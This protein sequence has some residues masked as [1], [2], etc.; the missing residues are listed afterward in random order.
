MGYMGVK[1]AVDLLNGK[2]ITLFNT[3]IESYSI[4]ADNI[5]EYD[6]DAWDP[7]D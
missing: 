4:T 5:D 1:E 7:L 3:S 6:L 2:E